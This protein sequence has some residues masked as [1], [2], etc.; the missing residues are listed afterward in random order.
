MST[1][2]MPISRRGNNRDVEDEIVLNLRRA[3]YSLRVNEKNIS[4]D[5]IKKLPAL[6][7]LTCIGNP[8]AGSCAVSLSGSCTAGN[9]LNCFCSAVGGNHVQA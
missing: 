3:P 5:L 4:V 9:G 1:I 8:N 7:S 6:L 2:T